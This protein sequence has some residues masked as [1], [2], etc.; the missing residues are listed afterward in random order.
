MNSDVYDCTVFADVAVRL[1]DLMLLNQPVPQMLD[2]LAGYA[3]QRLGAPGVELACNVTL[4]RPKKPLARAA[5]SSLA[6][7][8]NQL[9]GAY[10][11]SPGATAA[12]LSQTVAVPDL[13]QEDRWPEYV[14]AGR[15][16]GVLSVVSI[17]LLLDGDD[18]GLLTLYSSQPEEPDSGSAASAEAFV[19]QASK[20]LRLALRMARLQDTKDGLSAAMQTR[21][22]IDL[23][24]GAIMAQNRCGQ[25]AAFKVLRE[26]S[27]TRNIKLREIASGVISS[28]AGGADTFTYFD[29]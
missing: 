21:T 20:G 25:A 2:D 22:V 14:L 16:Q 5:S 1:Q 4:A 18:H 7:L 29:E 19:A 26:A 24:T 12:R 9:E 15:R 8:M 13:R 27:N 11:D 6:R 28:V 23:A 3:A 17:P 10:A